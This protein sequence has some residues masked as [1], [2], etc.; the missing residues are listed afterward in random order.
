MYLK[1]NE[2]SIQ[3]ENMI[4]AQLNQLFQDGEKC[5]KIKKCNKIFK[6]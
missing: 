5:R 1:E 6:K 4:Y 2:K 3:N